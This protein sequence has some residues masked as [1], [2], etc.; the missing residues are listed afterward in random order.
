MRI[1]HVYK[2]YFPVLGGIENHI[3]VVAEAH[4]AAGHQVIVLVCDPGPRTQVVDL[5]GVR[6]IKAG[7]LGTAASM[8]L[9]LSQWVSL[10]RLRPHLVRVLSE[11]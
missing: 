7:R 11:T 8:P 9:S 2:D 5:N 10:M 1:L 4:A 3:K 6:L